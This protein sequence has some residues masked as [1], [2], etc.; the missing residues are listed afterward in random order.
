[1]ANQKLYLT[2]KRITTSRYV[3]ERHENVSEL[4]RVAS[5]VYE[6]D[7]ILRFTTI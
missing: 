4:T 3:Y 2:V 6:M 5:I 1:M 7:I